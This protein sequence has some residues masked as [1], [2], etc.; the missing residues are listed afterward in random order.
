MNGIVKTMCTTPKVYRPMLKPALLLLLAGLCAQSKGSAQD[1]VSELSLEQLL[2]VS[3]IGASKYEQKQS[4]VAAAVSVITRSDIRTFGWRTLDE[5]LASLPGIYTTYDR[6]LSSLG[7]RGFAV[8]GDFNTRVLVLINGNR[9]N[10]PIFDAALFGITFPLDMDLIERIEF[11]PGPGGAVYGQNAMFGVVNVITRNGATVDGAELSAATQSPQGQREGRASWGKL[12]DNGIDVLLSVSDMRARGQDLFFG[13]PGTAVS[14]GVAYGMDGASGQK[15]FA[16]IA[17]GPWS[18]DYVYGNA[19]KYDPT[20]VFH[21]DPLVTGQYQEA[22]SALT[23]LQYQNSFAGDTLHLSARLFAGQFRYGSLASYGTLYSDPGQADW[24]GV[25]AS[26]LSTAVEGHKLMLGIEAQDNTRT[27]QQLLDL[28][29]PANNIE[30]SGSGHRVGLYG[31]DEW[32]IGKTLTSTLGLRVDHNDVTG[33]K[34]SPRAALIWQAAPATSVKAMYGRA[35]R[36]PNVFERSYADG[37]SQVNNL[38][39]RGE[40]IDTM[41]LVLDQVI[42]PD[43]TLRGTVYHWSMQGLVALATDPQS[44]LPQ[45]QNGE[46]VKAHGMEMSADKTWDWG[47]RLR[48]SLSWQDTHYAS[49]VDLMN[50]PHLMGKF[51]FSSPLPANG[52]HMAYELQ[53]YSARQTLDASKLDGYWLSNLNLTADKLA[54]GMELSLGLYNLFDRRYEHPGAA[55]NWQTSFVQDGRTVRVK[56]DYRF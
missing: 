47:G 44:G 3:I 22:S 48:A 54:R 43:L 55:R 11:I 51:N 36:A 30:L 7:T 42:G 53:N 35:N 2:T 37:V 21:T 31:Q 39:L 17:R 26:L 41:E 9:L 20:G 10:A 50:S 40:T 34:V 28:A 6:Q 32:S 56:L 12:Y 16:R 45:Y 5:A 49:G 24:R 13:F 38:A 1:D 46:R 8:P 15:L 18:F 33:N 19:R 52:L 14:S 25:E 23:Q 29:H 27:D 4:E